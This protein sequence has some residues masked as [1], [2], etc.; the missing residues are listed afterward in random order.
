MFFIFILF[1]IYFFYA[2]DAYPWEEGAAACVPLLE[3]LAFRQLS[4][5]SLIVSGNFRHGEK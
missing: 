1:L 2:P 4:H 3:S 5:Q